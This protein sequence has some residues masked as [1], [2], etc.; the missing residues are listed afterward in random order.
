MSSLN[1]TPCGLESF[2]PPAFVGDEATEH[3]SGRDL[4]LARLVEVL[5]IDAL[6]STPGQDT[7]PGLFRGLADSRL[8]L[9]LRQMHGNP[10]HSWT[11]AQ[12]ARE[13]AL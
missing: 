4:V 1:W 2:A 3:R 11:V 13:A 5:L 9:A 12:L 7:P 10:A 6:R 8:A